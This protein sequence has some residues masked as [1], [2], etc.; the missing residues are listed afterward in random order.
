MA[1][2]ACGLPE[3]GPFAYIRVRPT[4]SRENDMR[5]G[6]TQTNILCQVAFWI[7]VAVALRA[8]SPSDNLGVDLPRQIESYARIVRDDPTR[9]DARLALGR[10]YLTI[11]AFD[12]AAEQYDVVLGAGPGEA[13]EAHYGRGLAHAGRERFDEAIRDYDLS[14]SYDAG[15]AF[16][17]AARGSALA[18]LHRYDEAID[19]Y[20]SALALEPGDAMVRHQ[21]GLALARSGQLDAALAEQEAAV[22]SMP[23]LAPSIPVWQYLANTSL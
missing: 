6:S 17:H 7:G 11:E 12:A 18:H 13:A 8:A 21:L 20:G 1:R 4:G 3:R 5:H 14:I 22:A 23:D 19:A 16:A 2:D 10:L 15:R 9:V